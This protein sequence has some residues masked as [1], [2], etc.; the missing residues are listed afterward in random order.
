MAVWKEGLFIVKYWFFLGRDRRAL[1]RKEQEKKSLG[2]KRIGVK[3]PSELPVSWWRPGSCF[4]S[5]SRGH[6]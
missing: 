4:A 3:S 6:S 5:A 2:R 1:K